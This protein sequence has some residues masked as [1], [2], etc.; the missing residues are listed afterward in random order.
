MVVKREGREGGVGG[1]V[2]GVGGCDGYL[3][4]VMGGIVVVMVGW[5]H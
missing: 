1:G 2:G 4:W 5:C 3:V